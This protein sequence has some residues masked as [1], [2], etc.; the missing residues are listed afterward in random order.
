VQDETA[1]NLSL[2]ITA[3]AL[4]L[5]GWGG[6]FA[7][8]NFTD[9]R[10]G[11]LPVWLFFVLSLLAFTGTAVPFVRYL[12]RRF[13]REATPPTVILRTSLWVGVFAATCAWLELR[14]LLNSAIVALFLIAL[15]GVEWFLRLR[16]RSR[17]APEDDESA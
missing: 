6:L 8:I 5:I 3:W 1:N 11:P 17:W 9:P 10:I 4:A 15:I 12:S 2:T 7:L 16:E 13:S 14:D